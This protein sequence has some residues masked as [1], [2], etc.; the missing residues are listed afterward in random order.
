MRNGP[1]EYILTRTRIYTGHELLITFPS[2]IPS[3]GGAWP[4]VGTV[5]TEKLDMYSFTFA[6]FQLFY[7]TFV[8]INAKL[9]FNQYF[10]AV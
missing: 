4:S 7:D 2:Y 6:N 5:L 8:A 1:D 9:F 10:P 3:F